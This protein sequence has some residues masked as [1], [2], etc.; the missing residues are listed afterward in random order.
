[1]KITPAQFKQLL[2]EEAALA[3]AWTEPQHVI[4][5]MVKD[6]DPN[7]VAA[8]FQDVFEQLPG[9]DMTRAEPGAEEEPI[10]TSYQPSGELGDRS[11]AGFQ[12][13]LMEMIRQELKETTRSLPDWADR[14]SL[15]Q[16]VDGMSG[17]TYA[18]AMEIPGH[19]V[20]AP[21]N[22]TQDM[23]NNMSNRQ[24]YRAA[25]LMAQP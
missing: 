15:L 9:V 11:A 24:L 6:M 13:Q 1:M 8:L 10:P 19:P 21:V 3:G 2:L 17:D 22:V 4:Y 18:A 16:D 14:D 23:I 7:D 5:S 20:E 25:S 12:E